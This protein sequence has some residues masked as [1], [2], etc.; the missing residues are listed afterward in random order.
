M[1]LPVARTEAFYT[2][3][4]TTDHTRSMGSH[5]SRDSVEHRQNLTNVFYVRTTL[6]RTQSPARTTETSETTCNLHFCTLRHPI[7]TFLNIL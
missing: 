7:M 2:A 6:R 5:V 1:Q 4:Q 3:S